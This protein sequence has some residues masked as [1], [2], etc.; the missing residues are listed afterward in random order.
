MPTEVYK[1]LHLL[2][3][4]LLFAS[5][6]GMAVLGL[7]GGDDREVAP[8][9]KLLTIAH[10]VSLLV[11]F[12]AG[13]GLMA[14]LGIMSGWPTWIYIKLALWLV[15]GAAVAVVRRTPD[16]GKVWLWLLPLVGAAAAWVAFTHPP[17]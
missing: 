10:G 3:I 9:R 14:R 8:V 12:V 2:G 15:L 4:M 13:F 11:V 5:L 6:G 16:L 17:V 7:R 1:V